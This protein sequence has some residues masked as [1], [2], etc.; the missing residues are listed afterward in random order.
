MHPAVL[1][2]FP[3]VIAARLP[4]Q[5]ALRVAALF[6]VPVIFRAAPYLSRIPLSYFQ[7]LAQR[8][9]L[10]RSKAYWADRPEMI[11]N[12]VF[13]ITL[14]FSYRFLTR[15][16][17]IRPFPRRDQVYVNLYHLLGFAMLGS[18]VHRDF[19]LRLGYIMGTL[20]V[21]MLCQVLLTPSRDRRTVP[22]LRLGVLAILL[23]CMAKVYYDT[24]YTL[25]RM[26]FSFP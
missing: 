25:R 18:M 6:S 24:G 14:S 2:L 16:R 3:A 22:C 8:I 15:R 12:A 1:I 11:A 23:V 21:P 20:N 5:G 7:N 26:D 4:G 17:L 10:Y 13:F 19:A 9:S